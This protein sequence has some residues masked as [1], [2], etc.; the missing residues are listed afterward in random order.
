MVPKA[1]LLVVYNRFIPS[2][3]YMSFKCFVRCNYN[4]IGKKLNWKPFKILDQF[5]L[6]K[7]TQWS[8]KYR[9]KQKRCFIKLSLSLSY[10]HFP[11]YD[12]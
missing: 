12:L 10:F 7:G 6:H 9:K 8:R 11:S 3:G 1:P 2:D 4:N 5:H